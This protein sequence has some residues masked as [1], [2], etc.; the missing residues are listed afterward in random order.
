MAGDSGDSAGSLL[1]LC[2]VFGGFAAVFGTVSIVMLRHRLARTRGKVRVQGWI[3]D[4]QCPLMLFRMVTFDYPVPGGWA[5]ATLDW[6][7]SNI[8]ALSVQPGRPIAVMVDPEDPYRTPDF[9]CLGMDGNVALVTGV[10]AVPLALT[11][12]VLLAVEVFL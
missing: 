5:R 7:G 2:A 9:T 11:T 8:G 6:S 12:V 10:L 4:V 3:V 1:V